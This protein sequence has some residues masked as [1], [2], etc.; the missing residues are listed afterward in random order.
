MYGKSFAMGVGVGL[1]AGAMLGAAMM[2]K[3]KMLKC[4]SGKFMKSLGD[5]LDNISCMIG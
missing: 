2:P 3:K 5:I 4:G 1:A